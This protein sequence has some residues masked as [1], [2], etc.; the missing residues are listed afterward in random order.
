MIVRDSHVYVTAGTEFPGNLLEK[1]S[2]LIP[3]AMATFSPVSRSSLRAFWEEFGEKKRRQF[4]I[5]LLLFTLRGDASVY[6]TFHQLQS[7]ADSPADAKQE[8]EEEENFKTRAI[9][10]KLN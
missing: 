2:G 8:E 10:Q 4:R 1:A 6:P 5:T 7:A 3:V 9:H